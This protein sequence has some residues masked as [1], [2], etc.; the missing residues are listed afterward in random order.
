[1]YSVY[2]IVLQNMLYFYN[3]KVFQVYINVHEI[4]NN[5]SVFWCVIY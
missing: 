2:S 1:M 5:V 4:Y 3:L